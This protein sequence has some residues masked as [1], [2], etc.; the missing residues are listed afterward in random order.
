M[1][2]MLFRGMLRAS[3]TYYGDAIG[4]APIALASPETF[5]AKQSSSDDNQAKE[6]A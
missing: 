1:L 5:C 2:K 3:N 4:L 6:T